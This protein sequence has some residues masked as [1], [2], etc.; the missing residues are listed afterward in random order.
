MPERQRHGASIGQP[1][2]RRDGPDKV[3]GAAR[4]SADARPEGC[5]TP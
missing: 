1:L 5:S 4:Y 2:T 3:T